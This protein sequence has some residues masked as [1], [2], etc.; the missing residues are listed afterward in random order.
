MYLNKAVQRN[1]ELS[2]GVGNSMDSTDTQRILMQ[3]DVSSQFQYNW[4]SS[5]L[6]WA[7]WNVSQVAY[8]TLNTASLDATG[9]YHIRYGPVEMSNFMKCFV[10]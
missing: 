10:F 1:I 3:M 9:V 8:A 4:R 7:A 2:K 6:V 5:Y